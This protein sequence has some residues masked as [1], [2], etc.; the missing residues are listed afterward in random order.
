MN[1]SEWEAVIKDFRR[2]Y[3]PLHQSF[4]ITQGVCSG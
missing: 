1:T 2:L 4:A 3:M